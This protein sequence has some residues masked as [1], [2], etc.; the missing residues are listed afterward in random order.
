M[1]ASAPLI[2]T[3]GG[4]IGIA[5]PTVTLLARERQRLLTWWQAIAPPQEQQR[6]QRQIIDQVAPPEPRWL[7]NETVRPLQPHALHPQRRA[8]R[9]P[10]EEVECA[11]NA[12]AQ[13]NTQFWVPRD[14][15]ILAR[16]S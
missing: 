13:G 4:S 10:R 1:T 2:A 3:P 7:A 9:L 16:G 6:R 15:L 11:A 5:P 14:P 8:M 12:H